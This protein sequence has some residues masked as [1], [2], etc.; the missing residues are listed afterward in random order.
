[1]IEL[2]MDIMA[3]DNVIIDGEEINNVKTLNETDRK[4]PQCGGTMDYDPALKKMHCPYCDYTE[5]VKGSDDRN[6]IA[7]E[8]DFDKAEH[9]ENCNW[10][11]SKK[12]VTCKNCGAV[13]VY[14][15]LDVANEC[16]YCGSN[17]VME[18]NDIKTIAPNGVVPF[19]ITAKEA[20]ERFSKWLGKKLFC[21]SKAKKSAEA[22]AFKGVY[23]PYWTFD[24]DTRSRYTGEYGYEK[25]RKNSKGETETYYEWHSTAGTFDHF[26][27][28]ELV[29]GTNHHDSGIL[30]S[31]E[32]YRTDDSKKYRPE[33]IAGFAAE[34][35]SIGLKD[36]WETAKK[37]IKSKLEGLISNKIRTEHNADSTRNISVNTTYDNIKYKYLMLPVWMSSFEYNGKVYQFMVNGQSG[38]VGGKSPISIWRVLAAVAIGVAIL[39]VIY[40]MLG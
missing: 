34:R 11:E 25:K 4:C 30:S 9:M 6:E 14:D 19:E 8:I 15:A 3:V 33:Y 23:L 28:D 5:E 26:I 32:P 22:D 31:I 2:Y 35:Y 36:A 17:Q 18:A 37:K 29:C 38:K 12:T 13:T 16:P 7:E 39:A 27:D 20:G 21:P 24:S 10:G 40:Y 1:M